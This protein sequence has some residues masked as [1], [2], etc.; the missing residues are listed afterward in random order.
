MVCLDAV[1]IDRLCFA[2]DCSHSGIESL[3]LRLAGR[4]IGDH[5]RS[6]GGV[7][8]VQVCPVFCGGIFGS[9]CHQR[10]N[11]DIVSGRMA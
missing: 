4:G 3:S 9:V 11:D 5:R 7:F 8:G 1:G 2:V 10:I 6:Y